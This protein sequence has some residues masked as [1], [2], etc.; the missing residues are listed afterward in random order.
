MIQKITVIGA[1]STGH[2]VA[3]I[4]SMRGFQVTFHDDESF[5]SQLDAVKELGFIQLRGKI[6][7]IGTPAK[8][9]TDPAEAVRGAEAIFVHVP[10]DRHEEIARRIAPFVE[11]GQ[12]III[13]PGNLGAFIFR[14]VFQEMGVTAKVTLT[15]KEGNFCPCR[16]S[17]PAEVTVGMPL[18][19]KGKV[20]SLPASDTERVLKAL[21][22][23]VEYS[24][25]QNV[26]E[27]V[28]NAGNVIN[29]VASTVLSTAE[30][31]HK[32]DKYSLFK[33][34]FTPSVV[35]CIRKISEERKAVIEAMGMT[36]HGNPTG[37]IDK[38]LHLDEHPEV[39]VF[40]E[41]MD[42][43]NAVDH[44]YLHE[45]CGCGSAFALSVAERL[46]MDM[47]VLR[48]FVGVAGALND[49]DYIHGGR[50]LENLGFPKEMSLE[51]IYKAI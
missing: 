11:D 39:H 15:E 27:G 29:H 26:F 17:A 6:R 5:S 20:A 12:H 42:G 49:R 1:G 33:Y 43:P 34:A 2:A 23:V 24:A 36:V 44:R 31:D 4:M 38:V 10:A 37:M 50:T 35:H 46:G 7:G 3:G 22:G 51:D 32:G 45:D 40:Y 25:N 30:I 8:V 48:A 14:K 47:P 21:E 13:I 41:Y 19:L 16:L 28:I 18:N 9:T